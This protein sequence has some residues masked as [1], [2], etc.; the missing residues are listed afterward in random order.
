LLDERSSVGGGT[1]TA[2]SGAG[3]GFAAWTVTL[4][5]LSAL[6]SVNTS[7]LGFCGLLGKYISELT[8]GILVLL[9][10]PND[11]FAE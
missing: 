8:Y 1:A 6:Q 2:G 4:N 11:V 10:K 3:S 5:K 9:V 7:R